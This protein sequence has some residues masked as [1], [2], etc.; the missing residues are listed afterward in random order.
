MTAAV[1]EVTKKSYK[2]LDKF[3][4]LLREGKEVLFDKETVPS[5]RI[6]KTG[7]KVKKFLRCLMI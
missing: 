1:S 7:D 6:Y 2:Y 5:R 3:I 4:T